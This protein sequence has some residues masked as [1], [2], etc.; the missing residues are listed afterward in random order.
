MEGVLKPVGVATLLPVV[1]VLGVLG[2]A[3]VL[4][5]LVVAMVGDGAVDVASLVAPAGALTA[6]AKQ[7]DSYRIKPVSWRYSNNKHNHHNDHK[8]LNEC[9]DPHHGKQKNMSDFW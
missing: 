7:T 4:L 3:V 5:M 2:V 9:L 1:V 8:W 6:S